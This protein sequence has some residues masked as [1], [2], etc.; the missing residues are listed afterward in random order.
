MTETRTK[1]P[2]WR[3]IGPGLLVAATGVGAADLATSSFSG[4]QLGLG[5]LWAVA[6][7]AFLKY[8]LT[9][10]IARYQLVTGDTLI[11]GAVRKIGWPFITVFLVYFFL[12]TF[13]V[14]GALASGAGVGAN[15]LFPVFDDPVIGKRFFGALHSGIAV[16]LVMGGGYKLFERVMRVC[17]ALMFIAVVVTALR[18]GVDWPAVIQGLFV[19]SRE[20]ISGEGAKWTIALLGGVGGTLTILCYGYWIREE[21][22]EGLQW[23]R[24]CRIDLAVAYVM[25]ALFGF[26][27]VIIGSKLESEGSGATLVADLGYSLEDTLG[28]GGRVMFLVGAYG[29]IFSSLLGVWQCVPFVF[30]DMY[31]LVTHKG[32]PHEIDEKALPYRGYLIAMAFVS[33]IP[34]F[35]S[36]KSIQ[37]VYGVIGACFM[38]LISILLLYLN[39][40]ALP[41]AT[42]R[43]RWYTVIALLVCIAF[44]CMAAYFDI[45]RRLM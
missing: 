14:G 38:P 25:T 39:G 36:F 30:A 43:N 26:A 8:V 15:A 23:L 3:V 18:L 32:D 6:F 45:Q 44:F 31:G 21:D 16:A 13:V 10:G 42:Q 34:L 35:V 12:W 1:T 22:R 37:L 11:E 41:D 24:K 33:C 9:E 5:V 28:F 2:W 19:P 4:M 40:P 29:A 27:M 20:S 7:G 17:I